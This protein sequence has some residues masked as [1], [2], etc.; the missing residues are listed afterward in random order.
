MVIKAETCVKDN[1]KVSHGGAAV[2]CI[3]VCQQ[4][5][6]QN[7][8]LILTIDQPL[9]W[10]AIKIQE[11]APS[12]TVLKTMCYNPLKYSVRNPEASKAY[13]V[14]GGK[15]ELSALSKDTRTSARAEL[16]VE[17]WADQGK[18]N[19]GKAVVF[20]A[21]CSSSSMRQN[22]SDVYNIVEYLQDKSLFTK[23]Q[24]LRNMATGV[25]ATSAV[26]VDTSREIELTIVHCMDEEPVVAYT[27]RKKHHT[28][29][30]MSKEYEAKLDSQ[31]PGIHADLPRIL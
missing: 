24:S 16:E 23:D 31:I 6:S 11:S 15:Q 25:M 5:A 1:T 12:F 9:W 18:T 10:K 26:N 4:A 20:V 2:Q 14:R 30:L 3:F 28:V 29:T 21:S 7:N 17:R 13:V 19:D 8:T 27:F 22:D